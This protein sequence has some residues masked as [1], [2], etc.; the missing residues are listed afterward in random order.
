MVETFWTQFLQSV[1]KEQKDI[2]VLYSLLKQLVPIDLTDTT[3]V[4]GCDNQ[5]MIFYLEK[6]RA[7]IEAVLNQYTTNKLVVAFT[8][9]ESKKKKKETKA[10]TPLLAYK[11]SVVD[12]AVRSGLNPKYNFD[13]FAVSSTNQVAFAA[14]QAVA[15]NMG[16]AYNPLFLYGGVGVGKTHLAQSVARKI[17]EGGEEK[18]KKVYF[19]PGDQFT[20]ELIESIR[21]RTTPKFRKKYRGLDLLIVDDIQFIA[22][23]D[24]VQEE[25]FHTFNS[26]VSGG[27]QII[28]TSDRPPSEIQKLEDR[29]RSRFSGGLIVD[30]QE[31]DFELRTAILLIKAQEKKINLDIEAAKIISEN[32]HDTRAL[33]GTLLSIYAKTLGI[34]EGIDRGTVEAF[35]HNRLEIQK[36]RV[37]ATDVIKGICTFYNVKQ[38]HLKG[39]TRDSTIVL[40]RQVCMYILRIHLRLKLEEIA[41]ILK[42]KDHTTIIH[43]AEKIA[44]MATKDNEFKAE[45]DRIV[46]SVFS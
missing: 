44:R 12:I 22:G 23:K 38:S 41:Y 1:E 4:L 25:F 11:P 10:E 2:P 28:L 34:K 6:K 27:G 7:E 9:T 36:K 45:I 39:S 29:L 17:L 16:K 32:T 37:T 19:C 5:G 8:V 20:N 26:V 46:Q 14:A 18:E 3:I 40:P 43:G 24:T 33:E 35:F 21:E 42:R 30:I 13:N 31:P 15:A